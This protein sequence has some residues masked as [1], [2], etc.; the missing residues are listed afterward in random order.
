MTMIM[1]DLT[2]N[3]S[4][5]VREIFRF[6]KDLKDFYFSRISECI[7]FFGNFR[8]FYRRILKD[9]RALI[10]SK[11]SPIFLE[12]FYRFLSDIRDFSVINP[13]PLPST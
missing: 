11:V 6:V 1:H 10:F 5:K 4:E 13:L 2:D 9:F 3:H 7:R 12:I 8:M